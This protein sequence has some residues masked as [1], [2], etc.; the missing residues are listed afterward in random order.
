MVVMNYNYMEKVVIFMETGELISMYRKE[1]G[2]TIDELSAKSGV[3]KGTLNKIISGDTKSPTLDT[4]RSIARALGKRLV[5]FDEPV[6]LQ[7]DF[8][9][10]EIKKAPAPMKEDGQ[11]LPDGYDRLTPAN[12]AI[13]DR[14]IADLAASQ[15]NGELSS[16]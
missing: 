1:A 14:L 8:G 3:P 10:G 15:S 11:S 5:D 13:V 9:H 6:V 4:M 7:A 16:D 2:L 12:R